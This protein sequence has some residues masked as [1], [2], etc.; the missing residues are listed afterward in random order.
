M[1]LAR[2]MVRGGDLILLDEPTSGVDLQTRHEILGLLAELNRDGTTV[3][4]TTHDLNGLRR[5]YPGSCS[6]TA[7]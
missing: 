5:T 1:L 3:M 2:A 7:R 4:L 6:S